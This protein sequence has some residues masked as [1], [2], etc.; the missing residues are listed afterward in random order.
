[1]MCTKGA[2]CCHVEKMH[3]NFQHCQF[4]G[5]FFSTFIVFFMFI[6]KQVKSIYIIIL[7]LKQLMI[8]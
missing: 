6:K 3:E 2:A 1:M 4:V 7:T 5:F 8:E